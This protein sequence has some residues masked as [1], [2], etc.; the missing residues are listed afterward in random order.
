MTPLYLILVIIILDIFL[1]DLILRLFS[2]IS[3]TSSHFKVKITCSLLSTNF[4][5][6]F[7]SLIIHY[8][9]FVSADLI[10]VY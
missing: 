5:R 4:I 10:I 2:L 6:F 9:S 7:T 1:I 3:V 8:F